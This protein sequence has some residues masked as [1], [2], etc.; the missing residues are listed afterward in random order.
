[1][2][3]L[4][5]SPDHANWGCGLNPCSLIFILPTT[6]FLSTLYLAREPDSNLTTNARKSGFPIPPYTACL[7]KLLELDSNLDSLV[8]KHYR[9][10]THLAYHLSVLSFS[11]VYSFHK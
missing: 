8:G 2:S 10:F 11:I 5:S 6:P 7:V 1:M 4:P 3:H 9:A